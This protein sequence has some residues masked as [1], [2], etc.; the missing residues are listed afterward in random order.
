[1]VRPR[2]WDGEGVSHANIP[3]SPAPPRRQA[4]PPSLGPCKKMVRRVREKKLGA[5]AWLESLKLS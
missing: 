4:T 5:R 3:G 2:Q 1:M